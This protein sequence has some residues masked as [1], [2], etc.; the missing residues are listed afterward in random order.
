[1]ASSTALFLMELLDKCET[2]NLHGI[3]MEH[4]IWVMTAKDGRHAMAYGYLLNRVFKHSMCPLEK[5][6]LEQ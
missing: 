4:M 5:E 1:M 6:L 2:M 3:I